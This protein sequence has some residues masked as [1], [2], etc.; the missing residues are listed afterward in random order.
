MESFYEADLLFTARLAFRASE[1][2]SG[3]TALN[4][5]RALERTLEQVAADN[6]F[7]FDVARLSINTRE[8]STL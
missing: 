5:S 7:L 2:L 4:V 8:E 1:P 3:E 6:G